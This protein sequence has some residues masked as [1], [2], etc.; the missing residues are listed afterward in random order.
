[1][2]IKIGSLSDLSIKPEA[3]GEIDLE[4]GER[5]AAS[6]GPTGGGGTRFFTA[7]SLSNIIADIRPDPGE[8]FT[9]ISSIVQEATAVFTYD[10]T[11]F[12]TEL[13]GSG[14]TSA[15][16]TILATIPVTNLYDGESLSNFGTL[17]DLQN[18]LKDQMIE[19]AN[20]IVANY[21]LTDTA[22]SESLA[23]IR[24]SNNEKINS[25]ASNL[26]GIVGAIRD[27][28]ETPNIPTRTEDD[29]LSID[30][31]AS[32]TGYDSAR[33]V[34]LE[35]FVT[36]STGEFGNT[37]VEYNDDDVQKYDSSTTSIVTSLEKRFLG[38]DLFT[39]NDQAQT[40]RMYQ[41]LGAALYQVIE[42]RRPHNF[43]ELG[44]QSPYQNL[45]YYDISGLGNYTYDKIEMNEDV[46]F[47]KATLDFAAK[48]IENDYFLLPNYVGEA[49]AESAVSRY[50]IFHAG[51]YY[52]DFEEERYITDDLDGGVT[53]PSGRYANIF[54]YAPNE[55]YHLPVIS[56]SQ[57]R[58]NSGF[59][60]QMFVS[61]AADVMGEMGAWSYSQLSSSFDPTNSA[62]VP[63]QD[64]ISDT[65]RFVAGQNLEKKIALFDSSLQD[66]E[67]SEISPI[68][69]AV[70]E[71][72]GLL[73][74]IQSEISVIKS[75]IAAFAYN[76]RGIFSNQCALKLVEIFYQRLYNFFTTSVLGDA[77]NTSH[78]SAI[79][80]LC[81]FRAAH[82]DYTAARLFNM[83]QKISDYGSE[84][85]SEI[86]SAIKYTDIMEK[87]FNESASGFD[88][89]ATTSPD[90]E[91][92][93]SRQYN[94]SL[95]KK[96]QRVFSID[97]TAADDNDVKNSLFDGSF[98]D[99]AKIPSDV[100]V[101]YPSI[102]NN[103]LLQTKLKLAY[104]TFLLYFIRQL[105]AKVELS[106]DSSSRRFR[107]FIKWYQSDIS[108]ISDC[109]SEAITT[110][111]VGDLSFTN[112]TAITGAAPTADEQATGEELYYN[113]RNPIK[114]VIQAYQDVRALLAYQRTILSAE[115]NTIDQFFSYYE[116]IATIYGGNTR[117]AAK[118]AGRYSSIESNVELLYRVKRYQTL[119]PNTLITSFATRSSNYRSIVK[120]VFKDKISNGSNLRAAIVGIPYGHLERL[121]LAQDSR[122]YYFGVRIYVDDVRT[123]ETDQNDQ[124][125]PFSY[126]SSSDTYRPS[127]AGPYNVFIP[128][129]YDDFNS[130][131]IIEN[132][133][134]DP[135]S[136]L[137][138]DSELSAL[139]VVSRE[140]S[141][142]TFQII[143]F[144]AQ[145]VQA[146]LQSYVE[147]IY[148]LFPRYAST[149]GVLRESPY[150]EEA[151]ADLALKAAGYELSS[152]DRDAAL[153]YARLRATIMMHQDFMSTK[154]LEEIEA[155]PMFDKIVY[156]LF[157]GDRVEN[158]ISEFYT[159]VEV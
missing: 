143:D 14:I 59:I 152:S 52:Y 119:I 81:Y 128:E 63:I 114:E 109:L 30:T 120:A 40:T 22:A 154:M 98:Y 82:D 151:Y 156:V 117:K 6:L 37:N 158:I 102:G 103:S 15:Y 74:E 32:T 42:G 3:S 43:D 79:R 47:A 57:D 105:A 91:D 83:I 150:P 126:L 90:A 67:N 118:I 4:S 136:F 62:S 10:S 133:S 44:I 141:T 153:L 68:S 121:R 29:Q 135:I 61:L 12:D 66:S 56:I 104:Y 31:N 27:L 113:L 134:D 45:G 7:E 110:T 1:M 138:A 89:I 130:T 124:T 95:F 48:A 23:A 129:I 13:T 84:D 116:N 64:T 123:A 51:R 65:L 50:G 159:K 70:L 26:P 54:T 60:S 19:A 93:A 92:R 132:T 55:I 77:S 2:T 39:R 35:S 46:T 140:D 71:G 11:I 9:R 86:R 18:E 41:L 111:Q 69:D 36:T 107:G 5:V 33:A 94:A 34:G 97:V 53:P 127:L 148:G 149:K 28:V 49:D 24:D 8:V 85:F 106:F 115:S 25:L 88:N 99:S 78:W 87:F 144:P 146:A 21:Y 137:V 17:F 75:S 147:D 20:D 58:V 108:F 142:S 73:E 76:E 38:T 125:Y 157:D 16:P 112:F 139:S 100:S 72:S 131:T 155:S 122:T 96:S 145:M 101:Y 80:A